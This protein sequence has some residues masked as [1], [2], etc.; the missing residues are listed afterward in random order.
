MPAIS[1]WRGRPHPKY[2]EEILV[3]V[4]PG[5]SPRRELRALDAR[6]LIAFLMFRCSVFAR[7]MH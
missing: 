3:D 7:V 2:P 5:G 6:W 1:R 4:R